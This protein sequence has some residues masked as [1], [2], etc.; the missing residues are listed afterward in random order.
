MSSSG[1]GGSEGAARTSA[2]GSAGSA[3]SGSSLGPDGAGGGGGA[4]AQ[5]AGL[6]A[7]EEA[8][9]SLYTGGVF[10]LESSPI[11][12][13]LR[14]LMEKNKD[15]VTGEQWVTFFLYA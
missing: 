9:D 5:A 11:Y 1:G 4:D 8:R 13:S 2:P 3:A 14:Q 6:S 15:P 10:G 7:E 12:R